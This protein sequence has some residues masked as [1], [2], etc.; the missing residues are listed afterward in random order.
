[1]GL[2]YGAADGRERSLTQYEI[3]KKRI[4]KIELQT[5]IK[6]LNK[7]YLIQIEINI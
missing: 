4:F 1:M 7:N 6:L 3:K 5:L 2:S